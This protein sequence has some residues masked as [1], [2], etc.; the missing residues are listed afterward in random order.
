MRGALPIFELRTGDVVNVLE[1][2]VHLRSGDVSSMNQS[3]MKKAD[4]IA[5]AANLNELET[6]SKEIAA[7]GRVQKDS[8]FTPQ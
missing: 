1:G 4:V 7:E 3:E 5:G 8:F 6:A 2:T